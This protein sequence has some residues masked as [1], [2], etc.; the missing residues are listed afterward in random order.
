MSVRAPPLSTLALTADRAAYRVTTTCAS[1]PRSSRHDRALRASRVRGTVQG[2]GFRP[3]VYRRRARAGPRRHRA[4]R[5]RRRVDRGR[6]RRAALVAALRRASRCRR[7]AAGAHRRHRGARARAA[8]RAAAF[9][10]VASDAAIGAAAARI[11]PDVGALRRLPARA[12]RSR[13]PALP[14]SLHQLHRL[15]PAL[16]HRRRRCPTTAR[17]PPCVGFAMCAACRAE[18][19]DPGDRRFHAEPNACPACGPRLALVAPARR[20]SGRGR[21]RRARCALLARRR[22]SCAIK[23]VGGFLLACDARDEQAPSRGCA[24]AS[25]ARTSRSR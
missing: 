17:A 1:R 11:P 10:I 22:A 19:R 7:T 3:A 12:L 4:Q 21:A 24:S 14:L 2:V 5:R 20:G 8:R 15:R 13:R 6:G 16:H 9:A 23:G 18:Y 25:G